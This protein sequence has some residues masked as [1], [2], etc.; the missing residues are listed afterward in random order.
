LNSFELDIFS[1]FLQASLVVQL[2]MII[3]LSASISSWWVIFERWTTLSRTRRDMFN[4]EDYFWSS[5]E[6][7]LVFKEISRKQKKIGLEQIFFV[8]FEEF[9][10]SK[11][12]SDAKKV[13]EITI[14]RHEQVLENRL[15]FLST[16]AS[17]SPFIGL[18]GTV[19]GIMNAFGGLAQLTQVSITVVAPG[20]SEALVAT[21]LGLFTAI[22]ALISYNWNVS[23]ID[24][25][26]K[27]YFNFSE[28]FLIILSKKD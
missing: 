21:A 18:F 2:V 11:S 28:E 13:M 22:P 6:L 25:I 24:K 26:L 5:K 27:S 16:V 3:L 14:S 12:I 17:V 4:F 20:I 8:G 15:S 10:K 1:L 19:W 23:N 7:D 9:N